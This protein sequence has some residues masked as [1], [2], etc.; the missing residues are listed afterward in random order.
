M[1]HP[2]LRCARA[3]RAP[4]MGRDVCVGARLK[5]GSVSKISPDSKTRFIGRKLGGYEIT[6]WLGRGGMAS[7]Y[8]AVDP[9]GSVH[10]A[11]KVLPPTLAEY[12]QFSERFQQ[13][14][15]V[16]MR[17][18][19]PHIVPVTEVQ[20]VGDYAF[21]VMPYYALGSLADQLRS[22]TPTLE[23]AARLVRQAGSALDY[24]HRQGI[25]HRD[26]K[27]SN[28]LL[29]DNGEAML[30]DFG[31]ALILDASFSLTGSAI[32]GT[33]AY[34]SPEQAQGHRVDAHSDQYSLGIVLFRLATGR[35]PFEDENPMAV[36]LK[37]INQPL[38][39]PRSLNPE[40]P[41]GLERVI[42]KATAKDQ[43]DRFDSVAE[44]TDA[45]DRALL[46]ARD[47]LAISPLDLQ[48]P[49][50]AQDERAQMPTLA[51]P[52]KRRRLIPGAALLVA[53]GGAA[54][55]L[56][57]S[58]DGSSAGSAQLDTPVA[59]ESITQAVAV[60]TSEPTEP[61]R[62]TELPEPTPT[63]TSRR[64]TIPPTPTPAVIYGT[65]DLRSLLD[66]EHPDYYDYFDDPATWY[67]YDRPTGASYQFLGG[68]LNGT[69]HLPEELNTWWSTY[70]Q[71]AGNLYAEVSTTN[72]DCIEK[73]SVGMAV[74]VSQDR[75]TG[76]YSFE[77]SC[78]GHWRISRHKMDGERSELVGWI[79]SEAIS[80]G[81]AAE[82]RLG[83]WAYQNDFVFFVNGEQVGDAVD[84]LYS[85]NYGTFALFVR[86]SSTYDLTA[87]FDNFVVWH[88]PYVPGS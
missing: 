77:I 32:L 35:L 51:L 8:K 67:D 75:Q 54:A 16:V 29:D 74:R 68:E 13:E 82:N 59:T 70:I 48:V 41:E 63:D 85:F 62:P 46:Y 12:P 57:F 42:L 15:R 86:A 11:I 9:S 6:E 10:V 83:V 53:V 69:D 24:A 17:L 39:S 36:V 58:S 30:S 49:V 31:L 40:V 38:P 78:D 72:G 66:L 52:T 33:P 27:T 28:I 45:M 60:A 14:A 64:L 47:P 88:I 50:S 25:V 87:S 37:H 81:R 76:G 2:I 73:D 55:F 61:P 1:A 22:W 34:I 26:V 19:H 84:P 4:R 23:E 3:S 43:G 79:P 56:M 80:Q 5:R 18:E 44:M 71:Q 65:D 20:E 7:V 21:Q